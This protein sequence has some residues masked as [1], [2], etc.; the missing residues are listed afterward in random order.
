[1][2]QWKQRIADCQSSGMTIRAW[3]KQN[4]VSEPT[5]YKYLKRLRQE[6]CDSLPI[7][8]EES[9]MPVSFKKLEVQAPIQNTQ[10]AVVI[11]L[12]AASLE[13]QN[14]ATQ[15]TVEAV[16]LALKNIC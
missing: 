15:Q 6:V 2:E 13:I 16:L 3:C 11:H 5:Y 1:L 9:K 7:P 10:A 8:V 14:G 4:Q 12:P